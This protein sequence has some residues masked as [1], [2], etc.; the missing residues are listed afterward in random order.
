MSDF[1][2]IGNANP[3][4]GVVELYTVNNLFPKIS[5]NPSFNAI[6]NTPSNHQIKWEVYVFELGKWRKTKENDKTGNQVTYKFR[7]GSLTRAGIRIVAIKGDEIARLDIKPLPGQPK[8]DDVRLLDKSGKKIVGHLSYGQTVKARVHCLHMEKRRVF[9]TLWEDDVKGAGHDKANEK[10]LVETR[11]G[12]VKGG[13]ADIDFLLKPSFAKIAAKGGPEDDKIHEYYVTAEY[14]REKIPSNNVNINAGETPV[15]PYKGKTTPKEPV[16]INAPVQ[17]PKPAAPAPAPAARG[18]IN[19]VNITDTAGHKITGTFKEKQIKVWINSTGLVGKE[20]RLKLFEHDNGSPNDLLIDKN[21]V[22]GADL[23]AIIIFLD[24]IPRSLGGNYLQEGAEQELFVEV[25]VIQT[26]AFTKSAIVDVDSTVF[27]QDPVEVTN[28]VHKVGGEEK[29]VEKKDSCICKEYDLIWGNKVSCDFRKKVI[30]ISKSLWPDKYKSMANGLMAVMRVET[31]ETFSPSKIELISYTDSNGKKRKKYQGL[32]NDAINKLDDNFSGAVGLIQFTKDA[33]DAINKENSLKLTKKQLALMTDVHQLEYVK[34]Y[35]MLYDWYKKLL[36][37]E[38]IY[39]H[40]FAPVGIA[41][42]ENFTLYQKYKNPQTQTEKVSDRNYESNRSVDE[43]NNNDKKIQRSEILGRYRISFAEGLSKKEKEFICDAVK[44]KEENNDI[45]ILEE[46]KLLVDK[47]IPYSQL[48][49]RNSLSEKGLKGLDCSETVS[50]YLTKLGITANVTEIN[51]GVMTTQKD[52]REVL[53]S[54][55]IDL[56]SG[57]SSKDF[58]PKRGDIFVWRRSD[59]VGHT[60][61]VYDFDEKTDL[62]TILEAIGDVGSA[63]E[64]TNINNGG[65]S[66]KGCSRTAVYKR[67]GKALSDHAGWKGYFRPKNYTK[68]L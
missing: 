26:H 55:N 58:K 9:V 40:V 39:L 1:K 57:S 27:K 51:T 52:F 2:I 12:I 56:V 19:S 36:S 37:P 32:S 63:D 45:G 34:K 65:Y 24:T 42:E 48:G 50:I 59:G 21:Y 47:H 30:E 68:K 54:E 16:R 66:G 7:H 38:D 6:N 61:I 28:K 49:V 64:T 3:V 10:N 15:A 14:N 67:A 20:I 22:L 33:I 35:F 29:K 8:I 18:K 41:K 25:E 31:S 23:H 13:I 5:V 43:E 4:V 46:M 17:H 44:E 53:D 62:V 60:G 11:S